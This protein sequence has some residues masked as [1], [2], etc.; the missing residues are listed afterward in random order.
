MIAVLQRNLA[1]IDR[2]GDDPRAV[3]IRHQYVF[4]LIWSARYREADA[5]QQETSALANRLAD[6]RSKAYS[7][8]GKIHLATIIAPKPLDEFDVLKQEALEAASDTADAYI[9]NW[10]RFVIGWE[11]F[12][13][14]R[15]TEA[16]D[17]AQELMQV[18][19]LLGDPRST[20]L[21]LA[22][23]TWIALLADSYAEALEYSEQSLSVAV[24]HFDRSTAVIGKGCALVLLRRTEEGAQLLEGDRRRCV[25]DG[26]VYRLAGSDGMIGVCK[27]LQGNIRS[28]IHFLEEAI[29]RRE[30]EGYR[31]AADWY[32][33]FL[34]EVYLQIIAGNEK[35]S[36]PAL[37]KNLPTILKIVATTT[38][39]IRVLMSQLQENQHFDREGHHAGH[40]QMILGLLYKAKKN[41][42]LAI[43][44]LTA[45]QCILSQFGKTPILARVE[46]ALA[47]LGQ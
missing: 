20:G 15:M 26:D 11:E 8:A 22:L 44:H 37:L 4:A 40:L 23:M 16:R 41:R 3:L 47:E 18:G 5:M 45:A 6:S 7:L 2:L 19:R 17:V 12:H 13:R 35:P 29:L 21:G 14:G 31:D 32:R 9:Q 46:T 34:C 36:L 24:T 30:T 1:R 38:A 27:V 39:R 42:A 28:G 33:F 10:T 43:Q 25:A